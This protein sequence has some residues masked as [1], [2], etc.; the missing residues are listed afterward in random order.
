MD[1]HSLTNVVVLIIPVG[2]EIMLFNLTTVVFLEFFGG[3]QYYFCH[4][5]LNS[6]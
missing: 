1:A 2:Y 4:I 6:K 3:F 5:T